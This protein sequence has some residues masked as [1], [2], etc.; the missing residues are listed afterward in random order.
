MSMDQDRRDAEA[1]AKEW[2]IRKK[3]RRLLMVLGA[4]ALLIVFGWLSKIII[5][6]SARTTFGSAE[7]MR[8]ALQGRYVMDDYYDDVIIEGDKITLSY[9]VFSHY[10]REYAERYGYDY[11]LQDSSYDDRIVEWDYKNGVIRTKWM[12]DFIIDKDGNL[13]RDEYW[14]YYKTDQ[15][16]PEP[17]DPSTLEHPEGIINLDDDEALTPDDQQVIEDNEERE[18][19]IEETQ[20]KAEEAEDAVETEGATEQD[21]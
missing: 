2:Q 18:E 12:G 11:D 13:V 3:N 8:E 1:W 9:L 7:E 6:H 21:E 15:P 10:D 5:V 14:I 4:I 16:R 19:A 20:E 17:I